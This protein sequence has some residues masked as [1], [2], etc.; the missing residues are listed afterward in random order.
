VASDE[1]QD[2]WFY[3]DLFRNSMMK[4]KREVIDQYKEYFVRINEELKK[5]RVSRISLVKDME[6]HILLGQGKRIRP[7]FF[8]L[9]CRLCQ[10]K[11]NDIYRLSTIFEYAHAASLLHDD[12]LDNAAIRRNRPSANNIWGN[13]A[14]VLE[15]DYL[16]SKASSIAVHTNNLYFIKK[17][18]EAGAKMV[19]GQILELMH[20]NDLDIRKDIY[21]EIITNKTAVLISAAC[22]GGAIISGA[23]DETE[24]SLADFGMNAGIAFQLMD[25]LL[26]YTSSEAEI[27]KHVGKD[28]RE[29]KITLPLI[30]ALSRVNAKKKKKFENQMKNG[31]IDEDQYRELIEIVKASGSLDRIRDKA[32]SYVDKAAHYLGAFPDSAAKREIMGLNQ[33][34]V[35]RSY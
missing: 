16:A 34:M 1:V 28:L 30:Y 6:D 14:A 9:S 35:D 7:L 15:G 25:D 26:D 19:E 11:G 2:K 21:M 31:N 5:G 24:K 4:A 20:T 18:N 13:H 29:G 23:D 10:Y 22:A 33:Y 8:V 32:Q 3:D 17:L 12:V 27:G